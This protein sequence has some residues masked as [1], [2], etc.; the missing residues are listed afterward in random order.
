MG[1]DFNW[2]LA[3]MISLTTTALAFGIA[4]VIYQGFATWRAK[5][6]LAREEAYRRLAEQSVQAQERISKEIGLV[7][8]E[9]AQVQKRTGEMERLLRSVE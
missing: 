3:V 9:L 6:S 2:P 4:F 5:M 1:N 8:A 7:M